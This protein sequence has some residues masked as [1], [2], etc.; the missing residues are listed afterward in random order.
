MAE[1]LLRLIAIVR[2]KKALP[3]LCSIVQGVESFDSSLV[4]RSLDL[5][6]LEAAAS[7]SEQ[8]LLLDHWRR[9]IKNSRYAQVAYQGL[10]QDIEFGVKYLP[11]L[12]NGLPEKERAFLVQRAIEHLFEQSDCRARDLLNDAVEENE[13]AGECLRIIQDAMKKLGRPLL[14]VSGKQLKVSGKQ[15]KVSGKQPI[16]GEDAARRSFDPVQNSSFHG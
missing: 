11:A 1:W 9:F 10:R 4:E 13:I 16:F 3:V 15:L 6:W 14:K 8:S 5:K 12:Y 2:P 7:Y